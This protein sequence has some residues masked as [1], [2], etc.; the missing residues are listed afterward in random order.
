[1][2]EVKLVRKVQLVPMDFQEKMAHVQTLV[3]ELLELLELTELT[4][5]TDPMEQMVRMELQAQLAQ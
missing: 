3:L 1:V 4:E 5:L 2:H